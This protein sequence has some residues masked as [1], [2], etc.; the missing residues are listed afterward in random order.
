[1]IRPLGVAV[2]AGLVLATAA[3]G[4]AGEVFPVVH[5]EPVTVRIV[6]G[7]DGR[8]LSRLHLILIAGYNQ[9][10]LHDQ[11]FHEEVLTDAHGQVRLSNQLAN[12]PLLQVWVGTRSL[13]QVHPRTSGFSVELIRRDG[14][15]APNLCG[16]ATVEDKPGVFT[17]FVKNKGAAPAATAPAIKPEPLAARASLPASAPAHAATLAPAPPATATGIAPCCRA[18][19]KKTRRVRGSCRRT[20]AV[21][22][23]LALCF[24]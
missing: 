5:T 8:P 14:L 3:A 21:L 12:L 2:A 6:D 20:I 16:I 11:L 15:S 7:K 10:D 17:V 23:G 19:S 24:R 22:P 4:G 1:M 9:S 18:G 13:C